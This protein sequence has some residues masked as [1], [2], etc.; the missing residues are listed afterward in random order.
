M[1]EDGKENYTLGLIVQFVILP[2]PEGFFAV[3]KF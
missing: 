1:C 3:L 2:I